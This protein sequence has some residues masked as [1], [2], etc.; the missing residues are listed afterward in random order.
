[1]QVL[2][3]LALDYYVYVCVKTIK[4]Q[5]RYLCAQEKAWKYL[6]IYLNTYCIIYNI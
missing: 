5:I 4:Y 6:R 3:V 1:M 2:S